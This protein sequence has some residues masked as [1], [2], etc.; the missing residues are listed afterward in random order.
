MKRFCSLILTAVLFF[1]GFLL[2]SGTSVVQAQD[3]HPLLNGIISDN[4][5]VIDRDTDQVLDE[6]NA[7]EEIYPASMTKM[8]TAIL[9]IENLPDL[10]QTVTITDDMLAGLA[11]ANASVAGFQPGDT[12]TVRDLLYGIALPSGADA[13]NAAVDL[14][15]GHNPQAF[16]TMMNEKAKKLGMDHTNFVNDTGL[17]D[18]N[19]YST[20]R[21]IAKLL[22][23]CLQNKT[24]QKIFSSK[25]YTTSALASAPEG[26]RMHSSM[27]SVARKGEYP[28]PGLIGGK[29]GYTV[30]AGHCLA[31]WSDVNN[32]HLIMVTAH[33]DTPMDQTTHLQDTSTIL[34]TLQ[35]WSKQTLIQKNKN[36]RSITVHHLFNDETIHVKAPETVQMDLP[37]GTSI[38]QKCTITDKVSAAIQVQKLNGFLTITSDG[39]VLYTRELQVQIPVETNMIA[40]I[41]MHIQNLF[42]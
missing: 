27:W 26:I 20:V 34:T 25:S 3:D 31:S 17:H 33:A 7:D 14:I 16:I 11:E 41:I 9:V 39:K 12:P 18:D 29:A 22:K 40:R 5:I 13:S 21:D 38:H 24:F 32:M 1:H 4:A 19:H 23:Y 8:M 2:T 35:G 37:E 10:D 15:T 30:P 6:K 28:V 36:I 42:R